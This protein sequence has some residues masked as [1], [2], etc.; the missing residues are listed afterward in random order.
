MSTVA[1]VVYMLYGL[2]MQFTPSTTLCSYL[3][4]G[5]WYQT[6]E[7]LFPGNLPERCLDE[8]WEGE[9]TEWCPLQLHLSLFV[10]SFCSI[11]R[12][13]CSISP[14][15]QT[16]CSARGCI[17]HATTMQTLPLLSKS[18]CTCMRH[19]RGLY[20]AMCCPFQMSL[21]KMHSDE[22]ATALLV[23]PSNLMG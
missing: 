19:R 15:P 7:L 3:S 22:N 1:Y 2:G 12:W 18:M 14:L 11:S 10:G 8:E 6:S 16:P 9:R 17:Y 13:C 21:S 23:S 5:F 20:R 4:W